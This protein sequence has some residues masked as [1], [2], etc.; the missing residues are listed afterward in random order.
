MV[1]TESNGKSTM[2]NSAVTGIGIASVAHQITIHDP[3]PK[4]VM[5]FSVRTPVGTNRYIKRKTRGPNTSPM[6][7]DFA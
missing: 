4:I 7:L 1:L 6:V 5:A 3:S 2:G